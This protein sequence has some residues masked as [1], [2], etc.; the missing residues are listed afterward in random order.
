MKTPM[1][2]I[3]QVLI[4]SALIGAFYLSPGA[5]AIHLERSN[6]L[7]QKALTT[8]LQKR[9]DSNYQKFAPELAEHLLY[10]SLEYKF[11]PAFILSVIH[12]ESTFRPTV[13]SKAGAIGLM[14]LL[15]KTA[16]YISKRFHISGY[17]QKKNLFN[18]FLNMKLGVAY[19]S[20]LRNRFKQY[21]RFMAAYNIGPTTVG[22]MVYK[23]RFKLGAIE[24]Y[25]TRIKK[26]THGFQ[27]RLDENKR[28]H[29][30]QEN[31]K[32]FILA[33]N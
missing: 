24:F 9:L 3:K 32:S 5:N 31:K 26:N 15:P 20:Y 4:Y 28:L 30:Q 18:P 16:H 8:I 25:V 17:N 19:L 33:S 27:T 10:V 6:G 11:D 1:R 12:V 21:E 14:Q 7:T 23:N 2:R 22:R 29:Q 13:R